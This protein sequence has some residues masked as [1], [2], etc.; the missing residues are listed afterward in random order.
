MRGSPTRIGDFFRAVIP[1][2]AQQANP[3]SITMDCGYGFRAWPL[4]HAGMT[5]EF[6]LRSQWPMK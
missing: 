4:R 3:E 2:R 6:L 5:K 1:G